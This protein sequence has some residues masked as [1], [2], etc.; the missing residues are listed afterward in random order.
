MKKIEYPKLFK[1]RITKEKGWHV[2]ID[3]GYCAYLYKLNA[4]NRYSVTSLFNKIQKSIKKG[5]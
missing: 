2:V 1:R 4:S 5:R 3:D